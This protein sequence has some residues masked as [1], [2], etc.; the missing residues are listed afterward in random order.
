MRTIKRQTQ[1]PP[2]STKSLPT[3]RRRTNRLRP[4]RTKLLL[5]QR[6]TPPKN[7]PRPFIP[8]NPTTKPTTRPRHYPQHSTKGKRHNRTRQRQGRHQSPKHHQGH[9]T[10][11]Y[12]QHQPQ[13]RPP[14][15]ERKIFLSQ[16]Q[17]TGSPKRNN[18]NPHRNT[19]SPTNLSQYISLS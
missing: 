6:N 7:T 19:N 15:R 8:S 14:P 17:K 10:N 18:T 2:R 9:K 13:R 16:P 12:S 5:E 11:L 3:S 1:G 4:R